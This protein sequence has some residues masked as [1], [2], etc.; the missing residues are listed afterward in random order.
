[1]KQRMKTRTKIDNAQQGNEEGEAAGRKEK[2][3]GLERRMLITPVTN[4][5]ENEDRDTIRHTK[6]NDSKKHLCL[7]VSFT[8]LVFIFDNIPTPSKNQQSGMIGFW[9]RVGSSRK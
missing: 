9:L 3:R 7:L 4:M 1:M 8:V 6:T 5:R 2:L